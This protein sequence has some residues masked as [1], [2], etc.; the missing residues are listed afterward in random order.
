MAM[1]R[2]DPYGE[3]LS[4]Q[5]DMDRIFGRLGVR[6]GE[7]DAGK[8]TSW[9]PRIEA[10]RA[11]DDLVIRAELPGVSPDD[12]DVSL[13][14]NVLTIKGERKSE[15]KQED[16]NYMIKEFSYGSFERSMV[17][18]ENVKPEDITADYSGGVL[19][20]TVPKAMEE[21]K[22]KATKIKVGATQEKSLGG[23]EG[24]R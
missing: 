20:V 7:G 24:G 8:E 4:M 19:T 1:M 15:E 14:D 6:G 12:V 11:G 9:M 17:L 10:K 21:P 13:E 16:E 3:M 22:A 5:R 18:P 2:W 23:G